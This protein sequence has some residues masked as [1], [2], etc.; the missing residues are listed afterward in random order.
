MT[1]CAFDNSADH[2]FLVEIQRPAGIIVGSLLALAQP[3]RMQ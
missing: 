1:L 2:D 3:L